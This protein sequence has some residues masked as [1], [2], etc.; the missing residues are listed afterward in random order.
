NLSFVTAQELVER[1]GMQAKI[2]CVE[3]EQ[4]ANIHP[5]PLALLLAQLKYGI[6][7]EMICTISDFF[8]R[9][10]GLLYFNIDEVTRW[11]DAIAEEMSSILNWSTERKIQELALLNELLSAANPR[12]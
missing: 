5:A 7:H 6:R 1:Y 2:I 9:R 4:L 12:L 3:F 11:K 8:V 10:T